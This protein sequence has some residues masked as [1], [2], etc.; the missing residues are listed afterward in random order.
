[1]HVANIVHFETNLQVHVL[2]NGIYDTRIQIKM[3][4]KEYNLEI[5]K[6]HTANN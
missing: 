1:M 5:T 6:I 3:E 4:I 2:I